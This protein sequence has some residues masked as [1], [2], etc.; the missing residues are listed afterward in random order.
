MLNVLRVVGEMRKNGPHGSGLTVAVIT[1]SFPVEPGLISGIFIE[2]LVRYLGK[3]A[4]VTVVAPA[5]VNPERLS[6]TEPAYRLRCFR[7]A[8]KALQRIAHSPGGIP[9]ALKRQPLFYWLL[10]LFLGSMLIACFRVSGK[11]SLFHANWS[12]SGLIAGFAG[13]IA[14]VPVVT[15]LRGSDVSTLKTTKIDRLILK[16]C[17][18]FSRKIV[19]VSDAIRIRLVREFPQFSDKLITIPNGVDE[20][21]LQFPIKRKSTSVCRLVSVGNLV[22]NKGFATI[23]EALN[24]HRDNSLHLGIV[25]DGA[26]KNHLEEITSAYGLSKN[27]RFLGSLAPDAVAEELRNSDIFV[28]ASFSEGRPNVVLEAM[29]AGVPVIASDLEGIRELIEDAK[30]GLLFEPGNSRQLAACIGRLASDSALRLEIA[31]AARDFIVRNDLLWSA[32]ARRYA[33]LYRE[34]VDDR[35]SV[36]AV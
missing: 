20:A 24:L 6:P 12:M 26:E 10:P 31:E 8:P 7:Y 29:A 1:T 9:V 19:T 36:C 33:A 25:G 23:L 11:V 18:V 4:A 28:L 32:T 35:N 30:T 13:W 27:V 15:T 34:I 21:L 17:L 22:S 2:K 3:W 16:T 14:G 5:C